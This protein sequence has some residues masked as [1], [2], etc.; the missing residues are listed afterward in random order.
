MLYQQPLLLYQ[1]IYPLQN[2]EYDFA[3]RYYPYAHTRIVHNQ[4]ALANLLDDRLLAHTPTVPHYMISHPN[5]EEYEECIDY[6]NPTNH[7]PNN[8]SS[9]YLLTQKYLP[10]AQ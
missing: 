6:Y 7:F 2:Y 10:P 4:Q 1:H 9:A 8:N 3:P 5:E